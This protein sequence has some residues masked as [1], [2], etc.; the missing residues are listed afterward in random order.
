VT[1]AAARA[2]LGLPADAVV[3]AF[4]G[5]IQPLKA[6]DV[7]LRAAAELLR[8]GTVPR[9]RLVVLV[10]G[11]PSGTGLEEPAALQELAARLGIAD[12]MRFL[13]PQAGAGAGRCLPRGRRGRGAQ[14]QR[15]LRAWWRSRR[16]PAARR[17]WRRGRGPAGRGRGRAVGLLVDGHDPVAWADALGVALR[18]EVA[19][20][21]AGGAVAHAASSPGTTRPTR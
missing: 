14:P 20:R 16:R 9:E 13:P 5:R 2:A 18:P 19:A 11:G 17:W 7:L 10:A 12:C 8:R 21:L 6:P 3:L 15:V 4:V 1:A